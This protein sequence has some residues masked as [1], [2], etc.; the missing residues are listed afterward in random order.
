LTRWRYVL[1]CPMACR[2]CPGG[3]SNRSSRI[4]IGMNWAQQN[5]DRARHGT[6]R[7]SGSKRRCRCEPSRAGGSVRR[8]NGKVRAAER[9]TRTQIGLL[10]QRQQR[11][12]VGGVLGTLFSCTVSAERIQRSETFS[13]PAA[14]ALPE[15][16]PVDSLCGPHRVK[17]IERHEL[18]GMVAACSAL[19]ERGRFR[20]AGTAF[21][22][23][24]LAD[25]RVVG[26]RSRDSARETFE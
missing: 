18:E 24:F 13:N 7:C 5:R 9:W 1:F 26:S 12:P 2:P 22:N 15:A 11:G 19:C 21:V 25:R 4:G 16:Y 3:D 20:P 17:K 23:T 6:G 10:F 14:G 8:P